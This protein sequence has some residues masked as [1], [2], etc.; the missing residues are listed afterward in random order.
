MPEQL[1]E[2]ELFE[3]AECGAEWRCIEDAEDCCAH[4]CD[5]CGSSYHGYDAED[6]AYRCCRYA[7]GDCGTVFDYEDEAN[8]CCRGSNDY[9]ALPDVEPY[10]LSV[11]SIAGRPARLCSIEQEL[12]R[13]GH[14]VAQMLY[15]IGYAE[16]STIR[17]YSYDPAMG[18][19]AVKEDGSIPYEGGEV[20][21]SRFRLDRD[22]DVRTV[23]TA[24]TKIR[25]LRDEGI[26]R[27]ASSCGVHIHVAA[28]DQ[29]GNVLSPVAMTALHEIFSFAEDCLFSL[30]AAGWDRHRQRPSDG[31]YCKAIPKIRDGSSP[32]KVARLMRRDRY[33]AL[34]F[35]RLLNAAASCSCGAAQVG[36]WTECDCGAFDRGTVEWRIFNTSTK[37]ETLHAW[38]LLAHALTALAV[39][40][41]VGTL[42]THEYGSTSPEEKWTV[43]KWILDNA[44]LLEEEREVIVAAARRSPG[45]RVPRR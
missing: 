2:E 4:R 5:S 11:P 28:R 23:S 40:H 15:D 1:L 33:F 39:S 17:N 20:V 24:L 30:A 6:A 19:I 45:I 42:P 38:V 34:N 14:A 32:Q 9:P 25:Q 12:A 26:V 31:G 43:L 10:R 41:E 8:D 22:D 18:T 36:D 29:D 7:C 35:Q 3:C 16:S 21:Y 27:S 37:P 44:P 13:G